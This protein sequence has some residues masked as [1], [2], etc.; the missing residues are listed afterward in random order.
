M[1][2]MTSITNEQSTKDI[3]LMMLRKNKFQDEINEKLTK[4]QESYNQSMEVERQ[5]FKQEIAGLKQE[6]TAL[7]EKN[8]EFLGK[9]E[10]QV[11]ETDEYQKL[12]SQNQQLS[13]QFA[14]MNKSNETHTEVVL[15][16]K[17]QLEQAHNKYMAL[18]EKLNMIKCQNADFEYQRENYQLAIE[19]LAKYLKGKSN[20]F[21]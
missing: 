1:R 20:T 21:I 18:E 2:D 13:Q 9:I 19:Q 11:L 3:D 10:K 5:M 8:L 15:S 16:F 6:I 12:K 14:Q 17:K 7:Q 4:L